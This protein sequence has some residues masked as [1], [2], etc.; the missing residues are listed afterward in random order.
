[1]ISLLRGSIVHKS[2][3]K[4]VVDV[5]GV[6]Y[7]VTVP[8]STYY[9]LPESS[10]EV[11]LEI[12]THMKD[13]GI[14]LFGFLTQDEK[15]IFTILIG[16]T[17]VGPKVATN[18]LSNISPSEFATA[19]T[20]GD[21]AKRKIAGIGPKMASRLTTELKDKVQSFQPSS[22]ILTNSGIVGD[23]ISA[24]M[25]LGYKRPEIDERIS[26]LDYITSN[27]KNLEVALRESL[28]IMRKG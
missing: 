15:E 12:Y 27:E 10:T 22:E 23:V 28:K 9:R 7:G 21:L 8:L 24:L 1:M 2:L 16:V 20:S 17:G 19:I 18:I 5:N 26:E 4:V 11:I 6:G 25:N 14:E 3:G 13:S